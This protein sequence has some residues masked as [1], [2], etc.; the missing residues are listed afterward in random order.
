MD[1]FP[2]TWSASMLALYVMAPKHDPNATFRIRSVRPST[3]SEHP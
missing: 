3:S 2:M 1:T